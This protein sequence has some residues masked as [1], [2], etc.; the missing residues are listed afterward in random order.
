MTF[1]TLASSQVLPTRVRIYNSCHL[2][3]VGA[4]DALSAGRARGKD[5]AALAQV[6]D[7]G[8]GDALAVDSGILK[9]DG[10]KVGKGDEAAA[11]LKILDD[12]LGIGLAKG[13][14]GGCEAVRDGLA[15]GLVL[16][17]GGA[18][19][20]ARGGHGDGDL[21]A[22]L[23]GD[24]GEIVGDLGVPLIPGVVGDRATLDVKVNARLQDGR[25][26]RVSVNTD[27]CGCRV[28]LG[29]A[30]AGRDLG[31]GDSEGASHGRVAR[32]DEDGS[33]PL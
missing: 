19:L 14:R 24:A 15:S 7:G 21:V 31:R 23:H 29:C 20:L 32:A 22:G 9:G 25:R 30:A 16:D 26:A 1:L 2:L 33:S 8:A 17:H 5:L 13:G 27:P 28:G 11:L 10:A 18:S 4:S 6:D 12:P 3:D